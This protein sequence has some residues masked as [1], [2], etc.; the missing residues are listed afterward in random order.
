MNAF[1][2]LCSR[3]AIPVQLETDLQ[4]HVSHL[5]N[6]TDKEQQKAFW[7]SYLSGSISAQMNGISSFEAERVQL[8]RPN[9]IVNLSLIEKKLREHG[10]SFQAYFFAVFARVHAKLV[11]DTQKTSE[12][13]VAELVVGVY[14]ANR[15]HE[16]KGLAELL[17][18]T[19]NVVPLRLPLQPALSIFE[20]A[21]MVQDDL[22]RISS[23]E[24]C[25]VSLSDIHDWTGV[26]I[27]C[28]V[29]FLR[30]PDMEKAP[31]SHE[32]IVRLEEVDFPAHAGKAAKT[33][34]PPSPFVKGLAPKD[35]GV[36]LVSLTPS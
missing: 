9:L 31:A 21:R 26:K 3:P 33:G 32:G 30:L 11:S 34:E 17:A 20:S 23:I 29:N 6:A 4:C 12:E 35:D 13:E 1:E 16:S 5:Q 10:I 19:V 27:D 14:L 28:F 22:S 15:S 2:L 8:F 24:N 36:Y 7:I 25:T 18:P